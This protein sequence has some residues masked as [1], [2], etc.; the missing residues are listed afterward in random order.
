MLEKLARDNTQISIEN[1]IRA[2]IIR[3]R[4]SKQFGDFE[5]GFYK[6]LGASIV[7]YVV[8]KWPQLVS[9]VTNLFKILVVSA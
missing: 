5:E 2:I 6:A 8:L 3:V 9:M 1:A 4:E 7:G